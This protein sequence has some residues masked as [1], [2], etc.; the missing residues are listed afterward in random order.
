MRIEVG[1]WELAVLAVAYVLKAIIDC[2][3]D[4]QG[5]TF[6][7]VGGDS[8]EAEQDWSD[9]P[10]EPFRAKGVGFRAPRQPPSKS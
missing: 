8:V 4:R 7:T 5:K 6:E 2:D 3:D 9:P 10:N 1:V